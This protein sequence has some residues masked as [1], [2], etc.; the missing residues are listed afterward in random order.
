MVA[1]AYFTDGDVGEQLGYLGLDAAGLAVPA[2][3]FG[4]ATRATVAASKAGNAA[5]K[6]YQVYAKVG[7]KADDIYI[8]RTSGTRSAEANVKARDSNHH[9]TSRGYS[10]AQLLISTKS[11]D[12][13]RGL[14]QLGQNYAKSIGQ[15][16]NQIRG[17]S[18]SNPN[19]GLYLQDAQ[20]QVKELQAAIN[21][22]I[23]K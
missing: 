3:G 6:T 10:P 5:E 23:G 16:A 14:E 12:A 2:G 9:M 7:E 20:K 1:H 21:K 4:L 22:L 15:L 19:L 11:Y 8:G 18:P 17:I 13:V